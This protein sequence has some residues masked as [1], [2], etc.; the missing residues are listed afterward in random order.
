M[1]KQN[2]EEWLIRSLQLTN[3]E[4]GKYPGSRSSAELIESGILILDK[5]Q[6][7]TSHDVTAIVKKTLGIKLAGHSGTLDPGVSG[8][9]VIALG[10]ATKIMPALAGLEKEYVGVIHFHK[11]VTDEQIEN[12]IKGVTGKIS[13]MPPKKSAVARRE[14]QRD[15]YSFEILDRVERD[16]AFRVR[17]QA[18]TYI[19]VLCHEIGKSTGGAHMKELRRTKVGRFDE[20]LCVKIEQLMGTKDFKGIILPLE[21]G[22]EHIKKIIIKDSAVFAVSNG[23]PLYTTGISRIQN[24]IEKGN[25]VAVLTLKGELVAI[26]KAEMTSLE[27]LK[28]KGMAAKI[29]RVVLK[30]VYPK[31]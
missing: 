25:I 15:V 5:W 8:V 14:R 7:P 4:Y 22:I 20:S 18:G 21:A 1:Y 19:R 6:G 17:C 29:D 9:L 23:S 10:N 3:S 28:K 13:Q 30:G 16:V 31:M 27:M 2:N 11:D 12:A 26:G 24:G